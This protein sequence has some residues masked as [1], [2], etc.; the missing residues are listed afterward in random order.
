MSREFKLLRV[1]NSVAPIRICDNGGWTDTW[2]AGY[3]T[4]FNIAVYPY[5]E[6]QLRVYDRE[7]D[8]GRITINAENYGD[9]YVLEDLG[10]PYDKHPLIEA[11]ID[12]MGVPK[13]VSIDMSI[14]CEV[15]GGAS[16]GTSAAVSVAVIG[17]LDWLTAGRKTPH[18]VAMSAQKIET[19]LLKQQCGIQDQ[20][21]SAYGGINYIEMYQYPYATVSPIFLP[22]SLWWE[23]ESRL[24]LIFVGQTHSSTKTH[25]MVIQRLENAGPTAAELKPLRLTGVRSKNALYVGD[26]TALGQAMIDNTEAQRDLHPGLI[27][28]GHQAIIDLAKE[29]GALGWKVNG[30]GGDGGSI[31][32]LCGPDRIAKRRLIQ[33]IEQANPK[34]K[35]IP[36]YLS[37]FGLRVWPS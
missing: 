37:R 15:P 8:K 21:A 14:Y 5:V 7:G 26:F 12:Y 10:G 30:A 31:T 33:E 11:A 1:I 19:E 29:H 28:P 23:L 9:R 32:L 35:N 22:N 24:T 16:T 4:V 3:G 36:I 18:E 17:A 25:E 20:I 34:F 6:V 2:F 27:G 13:E